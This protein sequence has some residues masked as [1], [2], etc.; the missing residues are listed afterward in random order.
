MKKTLLLT[1]LLL[2]VALPVFAGGVNF[3]WSP[4]CYTEDPTNVRTFACNVN[5]AT[6][7][8]QWPMTLS[9]KIDTDMPDLVGIEITLM[10]QTSLAAIPDWWKVGAA[11]DCRA[12]Q[13]LYT[14]DKTAVETGPGGC[15]D[16]TAGT[17]FNLFG[18]IYQADPKLV[19]VNGGCAID[20]SLPVLATAGQ[21]YYGGQ[22]LLKNTKT[23][24]TG[25]CSGCAT[26]F[27][28]GLRLVTVAGLDGRRDDLGDALPGGNQCLYWNTQPD[29]VLHC[30]EPVPAKNTTW[31]QVKSLYR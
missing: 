20:A 15:A 4:V 12:N 8:F 6:L 16:W 1:A 17:A 28:M 22:F 9:W 7:S 23:V 24:G 10:G 19:Q 25:S 5:T 31:G 3:A 18:Y 29:A 13:L 2:V 14:S 27:I 30:L 21:E 11:P 26:P